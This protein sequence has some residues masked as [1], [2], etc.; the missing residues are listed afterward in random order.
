MFTVL[1]WNINPAKKQS[2]MKQCGKQ[3]NVWNVS[4]FLMK[5]ETLNSL[6]KK[7]IWGSGQA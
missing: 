7:M 6:W 5:S 1:I 3:E 2:K 4:H